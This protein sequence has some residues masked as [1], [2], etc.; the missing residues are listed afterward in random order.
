MNQEIIQNATNVLEQIKHH[1]A[2][3][4]YHKHQYSIYKKKTIF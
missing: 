2:Q 4:L 3:E 1:Q